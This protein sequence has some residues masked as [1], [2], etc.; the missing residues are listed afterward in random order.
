MPY[1]P[2]TA[3]SV[4]VASLLAAALILQTVAPGA[5][6]AAQDLGAAEPEAVAPRDTSGAATR[7]E[8]DAMRDEIA[9]LRAALDELRGQVVALRGDGG[10]QAAAAPVAAP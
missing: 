8:L 5:S 2:L 7:G 1:H 10:A 4:R 9:A 3:A 6:W